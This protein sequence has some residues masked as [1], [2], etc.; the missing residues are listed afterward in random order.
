MLWRTARTS[1]HM[2]R[3]PHDNLINFILF[4][5]FAQALQVDVEVRPLQGCSPLSG[6]LQR[7]ADCDSYFPIADVQPHDPHKFVTGS[8]F[9]LL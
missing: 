5:K 1:I 4:S 7:I 8:N 6:F 3:L 2:Q 9:T